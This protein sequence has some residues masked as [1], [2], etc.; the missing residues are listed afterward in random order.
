M[1]APCITGASR[2][3]AHAAEA[4]GLAQAIRDAV[5]EAVRESNA[6]RVHLFLSTPVALG[7]LI[8]HFLGRVP[9][10]VYEHRGIAPS[11]R[12]DPLRTVQRPSGVLRLRQVLGRGCVVGTQ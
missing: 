7:V 10:V 6:T 4:R 8:G 2:V 3:A 5:D 1:A 11:R 9:T 12:S